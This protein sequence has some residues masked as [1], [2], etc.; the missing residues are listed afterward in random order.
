MSFYV[1]LGRGP[2]FFIELAHWASSRR[3]VHV[4]R[5][6]GEILIWL[7]PIHMIYTPRRWRAP[8]RGPTAEGPLPGGRF[9]AGGA[10]GGHVPDGDPPEG[11]RLAA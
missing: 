10:P 4:T 3:G 9:P 6:G 5:E 7:G 1:S 8:M 11:R 2:K